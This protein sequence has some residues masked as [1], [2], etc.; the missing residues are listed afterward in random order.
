MSAKVVQISESTKF[1]MSYNVKK[2]RKPLRPFA[3][4][5]EL[6]RLHYQRALTLDEAKNDLLMLNDMVLWVQRYNFFVIILQICRNLLNFAANKQEPL[7]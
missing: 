1:Q 5:N 7:R 2:P 3:T 4:F 6:Q